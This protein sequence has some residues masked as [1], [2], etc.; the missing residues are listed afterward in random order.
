MAW[1]G[2]QSSDWPLGPTAG[3]SLVDAVTSPSP[4]KG[5]A[6]PDQA[7]TC[8]HTP[9]PLIGHLSVVLASDWSQGL[10]SAPSAHHQASACL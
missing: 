7:K 6:T 4:D 9:S 2:P 5:G 10:S 8:L 3:L 1:V